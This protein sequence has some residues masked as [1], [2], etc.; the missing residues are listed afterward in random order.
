MLLKFT[1][2]G[3]FL[4]QIGDFGRGT[5]GSGSAEFL[6]QPTDIFVD[7]ET[8]EVFISDGYTNRR[9]IVFDETSPYSSRMRRSSYS[10]Y[11]SLVSHMARIFLTVPTDSSQLL[12]SPRKK[13]CATNASR[14]VPM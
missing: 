13:V 5:E 3:E 6:G 2:D 1:P 4:L 8:D 9:L 11:E 7:P 12:S 10:R 14:S